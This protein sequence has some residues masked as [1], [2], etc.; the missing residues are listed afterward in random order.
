MI[1]GRKS[2]W[3]GIKREVSIDVEGATLQ[4]TLTIP[5]GADGLVLFAHGSGSSRH[6]PRNR[7]VAQV[8][9]SQ[10]IATLLVDL[11]TRREEFIDQH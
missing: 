6:S 2:E 3:D 8:L 5:E 7:Y 10:G 9:Q 4:G 11:L 1:T